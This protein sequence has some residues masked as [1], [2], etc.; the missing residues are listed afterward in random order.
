MHERKRGTW[1]QIVPD[2]EVV[3]RDAYI[4][5]RKK[6][7]LIHRAEFPVQ[8]PGSIEVLTC[9]GGREYFPVSGTITVW[10][11]SADTGVTSAI[12]AVR[13]LT[14]KKPLVREEV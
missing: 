1:G 9:N 5:E 8:D 14:T 4:R 12:I 2:T 3:V 11:L 10:V 6:T 13:I 7:G